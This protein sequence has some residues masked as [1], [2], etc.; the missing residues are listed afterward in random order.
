MN[1]FFNKKNYKLFFREQSEKLIEALK[2]VQC[3]HEIATHQI[4]GLDFLAL[5]NVIQWLLRHVLAQESKGNKFKHFT[6]WFSM[7]HEHRD[8]ALKD[9]RH[10]LRR[11]VTTTRYMKRFDNS[12]MFNL[13][14]DAKCT[15]AEY[16]V[17]SRTGD[18]LVGF[19]DET[20]ETDNLKVWKSTILSEKKLEKIRF[21]NFLNR[22]FEN[23]GFFW[24]F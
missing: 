16:V 9:F 23:V 7:H 8:E 20:E 3:P 21:F 18:R 1:Q 12:A 10:H 6:E 5:K 15:L 13:S 4:S 2:A 11:G 22:K 17:Y 14:M 19:T 24:F